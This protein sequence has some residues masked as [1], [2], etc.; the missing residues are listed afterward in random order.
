MLI[1]GEAPTMPTH[2]HP[3]L[4]LWME[5]SLADIDKQDGTLVSQA[6]I[7]IERSFVDFL[8]RRRPG[9]AVLGEELGALGDSSHQWFFNP[10][11]KG[12][13]TL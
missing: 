11:D 2:L 12:H 4:R 8:A 9:D 1:V 7:E 5:Y 10:I 3:S 13:R 6:D